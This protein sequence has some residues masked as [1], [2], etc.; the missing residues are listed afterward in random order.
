[1]YSNCYTEI[2]GFI[3]WNENEKKWKV[4]KVW[5][6]N[7]K[8]LLSTILNHFQPLKIILSSFE[9]FKTYFMMKNHFDEAEA[10]LNHFAQIW[11]F[12]T[13]FKNLFELIII[14]N[15]LWTIFN[16]Y[17]E[18]CLQPWPSSEY[19]FKGSVNLFL[20]TV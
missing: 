18:K 16:H 10:I 15:P 17:N 13:I 12:W 1:M 3:F 2:E 6:D 20:N 9:L 14:S 19:V 4:S 8:R 7:F 11:S 5:N